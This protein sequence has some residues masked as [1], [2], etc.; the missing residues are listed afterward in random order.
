MNAMKYVTAMTYRG[1][2]ILEEAH[3]RHTKLPLGTG[4]PLLRGEGGWIR[5]T[6]VGAW[7]QEVLRQRLDPREVFQLDWVMGRVGRLV[8]GKSDNFIFEN[9]L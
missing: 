9:R 8:G 5:A 2:F 1:G 6:F 7:R 4:G 3:I